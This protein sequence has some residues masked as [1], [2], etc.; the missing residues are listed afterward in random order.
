MTFLIGVTNCPGTFLVSVTG[1]RE[2]FL[3]GVHLGGRAHQLRIID[4]P[5]RRWTQVSLLDK[6][7]E[8]RA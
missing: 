1:R 8:R 4:E 3:D 2:T 6:P 5:I 7:V